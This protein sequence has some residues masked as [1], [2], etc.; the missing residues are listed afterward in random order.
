MARD[1]TRFSGLRHQHLNAEGIAFQRFLVPRY[2]NRCNGMKPAIPV[3]YHEFLNHLDAGLSVGQFHCN[4]IQVLSFDDFEPTAEGVFPS[5][6]NEGSR[7]IHGV[8]GGSDCER[9]LVTQC[10]RIRVQGHRNDLG[11]CSVYSGPKHPKEDGKQGHCF[12]SVANEIN[13]GG[14]KVA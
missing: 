3:G 6:P 2:L 4:R 9:C 5:G 11:I 10:N 14:Q 13:H 8:A 1:L 7:A 12:G